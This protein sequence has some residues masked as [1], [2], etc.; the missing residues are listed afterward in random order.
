MKVY[1]KADNVKTLQSMT[2]FLAKYEGNA[3][4]EN[5]VDSLTMQT[6]YELIEAAK[7][8]WPTLTST[9]C[10]LDIMSTVPLLLRTVCIA[11]LPIGIHKNPWMVEVVALPSVIKH[12]NSRDFFK[13]RHRTLNG[14]LFNSGYLINNNIKQCIIS[15]G[16]GKHISSYLLSN[17]TEYFH[18]ET[19]LAMWASVIV[20][21]LSKQTLCDWMREELDLISKLNSVTYVSA[22]SSWNKYVC[23][24]EGEN[25]RLAL[26]TENPSL[27]SHLKCPH[28]NKFIMACYFLKDRLTAEQLKSRRNALNFTVET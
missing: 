24:V 10:I 12:V 8:A 16:V 2:K 23:Q 17:D 3:A 15:Q 11:P 26:V 13:I 4:D 1:F 18:P 25:F 21:L 28:I 6:Q 5:L 27:P 22:K 19:D 14:E 20:M 7:I 9:P